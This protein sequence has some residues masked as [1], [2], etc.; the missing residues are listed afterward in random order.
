MTQPV[1]PYASSVIRRDVRRAGLL[2]IIWGS[3]QIP[4]GLLVTIYA[5]IAIDVALLPDSEFPRLLVLLIAPPFLI[6]GVI[7]AFWGIKTVKAG[8]ALIQGRVQPLRFHI[9]LTVIAE[10]AAYAGIVVYILVCIHDHVWKISQN[11]IYAILFFPL[12]LLLP[13]ALTSTR[14]TLKRAS[15][16]LTAPP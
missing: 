13:W 1:I 3:L 4:A 8:T 12:Y 11:L 16:T 10:F 5:A 15:A 2:L 7:L 14:L 6:A 9:V